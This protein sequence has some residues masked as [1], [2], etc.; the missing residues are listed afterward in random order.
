MYYLLHLLSSNCFAARGWC[1]C[2]LTVCTG[3]PKRLWRRQMFTPTVMVIKMS[4]LAQFFLFS[5]DNS[6]NVVPV[7]GKYESGPERSF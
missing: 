1:L 4:K 7:W 6:I 5:A 2:G 3:L